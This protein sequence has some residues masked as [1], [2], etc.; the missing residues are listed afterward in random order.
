M[1]EPLTRPPAPSIPVGSGYT[2]RERVAGKTWTLVARRSGARVG[3]VHSP[4]GASQ[5]LRDYLPITELE[6]E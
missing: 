2:Y 6:T 5:E 3:L 4:G 1:P